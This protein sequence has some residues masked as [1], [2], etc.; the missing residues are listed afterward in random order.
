MIKTNRISIALILIV[1]N[2]E[3]GLNK[4]LP[5]ID[6]NLFDEILAIDGNSKDETKELI[7]K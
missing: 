2:E 6:F 5:K 7:K 4:T 1:M 3:F